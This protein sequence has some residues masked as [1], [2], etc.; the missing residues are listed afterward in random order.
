MARN[1]EIV[2][3][4]GRFNPPHPGHFASIIRLSKIFK[5]V[6]V[7]IL[8]YPNRKWPIKYCLNVF[9]EIFA[10]MEKVNPRFIVN[11]VHFGV[12]K[13]GQLEQFKPFHVY[14]AGNLSVL[15]NFERLGV[16]VFYLERAFLYSASEIKLP[17][18]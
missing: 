4:S 15:R 2:L 9:Q 14:A 11:V 12:I 3:F 13:E 8:D 16:P 17:K 10:P 5:T 1:N 18:S 6:K 7:V